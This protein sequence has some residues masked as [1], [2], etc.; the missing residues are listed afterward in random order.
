ML[1]SGLSKEGCWMQEREMRKIFKTVT[2]KPEVS[3]IL[4][5]SVWVLA[6]Y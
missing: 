6:C 2:G 3:R 5:I 4:E 1:M